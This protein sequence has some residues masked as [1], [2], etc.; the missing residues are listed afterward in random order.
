ML[1]NTFK[2][3]PVYRFAMLKVIEPYRIQLSFGLPLDGDG[4][5]TAVKGIIEGDN[6]VRCLHPEWLQ[7]QTLLPR[8]VFKIDVVHGQTVS[9]RDGDPKEEEVTTLSRLQRSIQTK[10]KSCDFA[11]EDDSFE[12]CSALR[13]SS[14]LDTVDMVMDTLE[15]KTNHI[16]YVQNMD[17]SVPLCTTAN[18]SM[19]EMVT[20]LEELGNMPI[21]GFSKPPVYVGTE[22]SVF[23]CHRED[24]SFCALN[25]HIAGA[26]KVWFCV[27]P[28]Y[29]GAFY[30]MIRNLP[31]PEE[32]TSPLCQVLHK[33]IWIDPRMIISCGI[34]VYPDIVLL[35]PNT[36]HW[37][38]NMCFNVNEAIN[39]VNRSWI[40]PGMLSHQRCKWPYRPQGNTMQL[41]P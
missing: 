19:T 40:L 30:T 20:G 22:Y 18:S 11:S 25:R 16:V 41:L 36:I 10:I 21:S 39:L 35:L 38:Y 9:V 33:E 3:G 6:A 28:A 27:P 29:Y 7:R 13:N 24:M 17:L 12:L 14:L 8:T 4:N 26:P 31:I 34:P 32:Q 15:N 37:G 2:S 1:P 5:V 23:G